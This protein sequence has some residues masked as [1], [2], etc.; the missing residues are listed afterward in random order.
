MILDRFR[1]EGLS[2]VVTAASRGIGAAT[3]LA[4]AEAGADVVVAARSADALGAVAA[5]V[6]AT[7]RRAEV[8]VADLDDLQAAD[9]LVETARRSFGRLDIVVNNVGG[10][11]PRPFLDTSP[12]Y[13]ERAFHFNVSTAHAL[14]RAA[15][16]LLL[17]GGGGAVVNISSTAARIPDRGYVAYATAKAALAQYTRNAA[18]DLAPRIR[19]NGIYP[20]AI[21]TSALDAVLADD[22]LRST[23]EAAT[24]LRRLGTAEDI[25]AAVVYLVSPAGGY[26]TG[27]MLEVD[28]GLVAPQLDLGLADL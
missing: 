15:V 14:T 13:L 19:V 2:A 5:Q 18:R 11:M 26:L 4:L 20:G 21:A 25:A 7:G 9:V 10:A 16:P 8:V 27:K 3:A 12:G 1:L 23:M 17:Q 24:P 28:G 6:E 22:G